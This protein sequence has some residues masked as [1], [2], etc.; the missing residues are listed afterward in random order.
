[1]ESLRMLED[2]ALQSR[3]DRLKWDEQDLAERVGKQRARLESENRWNA[4]D[5]LYQR[6]FFIHARIRK[7]LRSSELEVARRAKNRRA[8][9]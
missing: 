4:S 8:R 9:A 3:I 7:D 6:L 1:M 5:P 2:A